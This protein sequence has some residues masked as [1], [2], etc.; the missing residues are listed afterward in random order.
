MSQWRAR[1]GVSSQHGGNPAQLSGGLPVPTLSHTHPSKGEAQSWAL[2]RPPYTASSP[3]RS[4]VPSWGSPWCPRSELS[5]RAREASSHFSQGN[6]KPARRAPRAQR[7]RL[8]A[9]WCL[10]CHCHPQVKGPEKK[11]RQHCGEGHPLSGFT[12]PGKTPHLP[13]CSHGN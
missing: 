2:H 5:G 12:K 7:H 9:V 10:H 13:L 1:E 11:G 8:G 3:Y 6:P 4:S